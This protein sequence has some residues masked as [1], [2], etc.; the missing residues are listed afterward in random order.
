MCGG[1]VYGGRRF[2]TGTSRVDKVGNPQKLLTD[3]RKRMITR[4]QK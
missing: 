1:T 3:L 2:N 4:R